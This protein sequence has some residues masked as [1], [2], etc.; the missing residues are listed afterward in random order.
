MESGWSMYVDAPMNAL[1]TAVGRA[2]YTLASRRLHAND[3]TASHTSTTN[4]NHDTHRDAPLHAYGFEVAHRR[5]VRTRELVRS[6][7]I[8]HA[9]PMPTLFLLVT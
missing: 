8:T 3:T 7:P 2:P 1:H 4:T 6:L 9:S 5:A